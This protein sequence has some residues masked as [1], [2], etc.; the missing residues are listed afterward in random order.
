MCPRFDDDV[1]SQ[2]ES[3]RRRGRPRDPE[4]EGR[5]LDAAVEEYAERGW[6]GLTMDGVARRAGVGKSTLYLRWPDKGTLLAAAVEAIATPLAPSDTGSLRG[7]LE[8][9]ARQLRAWYADPRGWAVTRIWIDAASSGQQVGHFVDVVNNHYRPAALALFERAVERGEAR[10][11]VPAQ[12]V[13]NS[14]Y[15][16]LFMYA[17]MRP[18]DEDAPDPDDEGLVQELVGFWMRGM[19]PWLV[20]GAEGSG[21]V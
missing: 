15:G 19:A 3:S 13:V 6:A 16:V 10:A 12:L 14:I 8:L 7:D 4:L 2:L 11:D 20:N 18:W 5:V 21:T 9:L 1:Q 17:S